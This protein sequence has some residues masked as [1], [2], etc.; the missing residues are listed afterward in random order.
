MN[1]TTTDTNLKKLKNV[2][3]RSEE[4]PLPVFAARAER[5]MLIRC[6]VSSI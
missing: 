5:S 6:S 1:K 2:Y 4:K 3:P